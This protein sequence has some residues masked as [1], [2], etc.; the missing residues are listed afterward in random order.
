[1][2]LSG[3]VAAQTGAS[4]GQAS[5]QRSD[6]VKI[7]HVNPANGTITVLSIPRDT[8]TTLLANQGLYGKANRLNVNFGTGPSLLAQTITANFGIPIAHTIVVGFAGIINA[9][10][11]I[12]GVY[13]NFPYPAKDAYSA[14]NIP[15]AGCQLI[16]NFQALALVRSRHY[17]WF[18]NGIWNFDVTS[19]YGR[20]YR[21]NE[22]IK[23]MIQRAKGLYNPITINSFLSKLPTGI[24]L[25]SRFSLSELV[26]L[27]IK[28]HSIDPANL[29]TYTLPTTPGSYG[30]LGSILLVQEPQMQQLLFKIFG[31]Q[32][33][34]PTNPPPVN[35]AGATPSWTIPSATTTTTVKTSSI[36][37]PSKG[38][39][40]VNLAA[41]TNTPVTTTT[42]APE[43]DQFF[44]P[45]P[46]TP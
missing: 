25:D 6:V 16:T 27:V 46:C 28:F 39:F 2:G 43:G 44:D 22:F 33:E 15:H 7:M 21:Q 34:K 14:L 10:N 20:I 30:N 29:L 37:I 3:Y 4:T 40:L 5:G 38:S 9:A 12:G 19:D 23:G 42:V 18:Q 8:V 35:S 13:M 45:T 26:G 1:V 24:A 17:E 11:A 32:L 36:E 41:S 31:S